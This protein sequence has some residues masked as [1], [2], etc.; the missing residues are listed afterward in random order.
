[1]V[2]VDQQG[3]RTAISAGDL[4]VGMMVLS[5]SGSVS[6]ILSI[7]PVSWVGVFA[8]FTPSGMI[9]IGDVLMSTYVAVSTLTSFPNQWITHSFM[10]PH[11]VW[12]HYL[13]QCLNES[14]TESGISTSMGRWSSQICSVALCP[15]S[16]NDGD[17]YGSFGSNL[18]RVYYI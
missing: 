2:F 1:M 15:V 13:G 14:Y 7:K 17:L 18:D 16:G 6:R 11:R 5:S 10:L 4:K 12:G 3:R 8:P 9:V